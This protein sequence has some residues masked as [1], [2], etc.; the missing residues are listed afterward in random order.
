MGFAFYTGSGNRSATNRLVKQSRWFRYFGSRG[1][2]F[3]TGLDR[4]RFGSRTVASRKGSRFGISLPTGGNSASS[5]GGSRKESFMIFGFLFRRWFSDIEEH[6]EEIDKHERAIRE[7]RQRLERL[8]H[9][10]RERDLYRRRR[11]EQTG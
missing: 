5:I 8:R 11:G 9:L 4:P 7:Q 10:E 2:S 3:F 1:G 6:R